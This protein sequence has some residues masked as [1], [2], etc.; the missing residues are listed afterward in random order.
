MKQVIVTFNFDP[1]TELV[2][3]V[4]CSIDGVEKKKK[5][6]KTKKDIVTELEDEA[7][8]TLESNK[9]V[10]NNKAA[11]VLEIAHESRIIIKWIPEGKKMVP[12]IGTDI[13][14]NEEGSG[15]KVTKSNT[16][17]YKGNAN[18][19]LSEYGTVFSLK[20]YK[21]ELWKLVS[22]KVGGTI[23]KPAEELD[24]VIAQAELVE[25]ELLTEL[26]NDIEIDE[27]TFQL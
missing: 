1:E 9:L 6:T 18:T 20:P 19:I 23:S 21:D 4:K 5:T 3:D 2:S 25:P 13:A 16:V 14:F 27:L 22:N 24:T 15:N 11:S 7:V 17:T 10:F 26:D 12:I 8:I